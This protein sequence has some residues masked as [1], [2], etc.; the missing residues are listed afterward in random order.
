MLEELTV[1]FSVIMLSQPTEFCVVNVAEL[2]DVIYETPSIQ[3]NV[4]QVN[5]VSTEDVLEL[6][7]K[8]KV[9]ILSHP[10]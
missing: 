5:C 10:V 6:I 8:F 4:L 9:I 2:L 7:F 1:K 3:V